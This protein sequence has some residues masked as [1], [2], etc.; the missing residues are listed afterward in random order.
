[1]AR[2]TI[3]EMTDE[4]V[5]SKWELE[6]A[7]GGDIRYFAFPFG[8]AKN[9]PIE[10]VRI[11]MRAGYRGICSAYGAYNVPWGDPFHVKR[12]HADPQW[13]RFVNWMTVDPRKV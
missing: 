8:L 1:L 2:A 12:I 5:R 3:W 13:T 10:A 11:A 7:L 9:M 6:D 4:I